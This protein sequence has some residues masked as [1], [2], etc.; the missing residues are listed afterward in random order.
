MGVAV[1]TC[2]RGPSIIYRQE[3]CRDL[4]LSCSREN[5]MIPVRLVVTGSHDRQAHYY[6]TTCSSGGCSLTFA[7]LSKA[8]FAIA[9]IHQSLIECSSYCC[10][11]TVDMKYL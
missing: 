9:R 7:P 11:N 3:A 10:S 5:S 1:L 4:Q 8:A 2:G 6:Y